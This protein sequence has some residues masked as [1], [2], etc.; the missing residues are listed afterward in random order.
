MKPCIQGVLISPWPVQE[1]KKLQQ[2]KVLSF[3]YAICSNNW[4]NISSI[5][6]Y[7]HKYIYIYIYIKQYY[8]QKKYS[9]HQTKYIE[10]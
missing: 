6:I 7:I 2:Q 5:Y 10:K 1:G 8:H 4:R 3:I 9:H